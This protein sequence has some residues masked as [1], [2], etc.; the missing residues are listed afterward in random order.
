[1]EKGDDLPEIQDL[2]VKGIIGFD[3]AFLKFKKLR[4]IK[5]FTVDAFFKEIHKEGSWYTQMGYM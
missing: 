5:K 4:F 3:G 1:M 2:K